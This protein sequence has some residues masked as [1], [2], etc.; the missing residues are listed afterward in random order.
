MIKINGINILWLEAKITPVMNKKGDNR[1]HNQHRM[2]IHLMQSV[3][4]N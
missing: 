3:L 1:D 2:S 4:K